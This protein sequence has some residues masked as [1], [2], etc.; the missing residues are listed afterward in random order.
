MDADSNASF[1]QNAV[2]IIPEDN[3]NQGEGKQEELRQPETLTNEE[4]EKIK[5][6]KICKSNL[7]GNYIFENVQNQYIPL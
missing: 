1:D 3:V 2:D 4:Y 5:R 7:K 6:P